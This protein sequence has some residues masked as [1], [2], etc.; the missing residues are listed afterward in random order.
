[1]D[2]SNDSAAILA[3]HLRANGVAVVWTDA[4][5]LSASHPLHSAACED[6]TAEADRYVTSYGYEVGQYG[7]EREAA[8]RISHLVEARSGHESLP[9]D[10]EAISATIRRALCLGSG[11]PEPDALTELEEELRGHI[12]LLLPEVRESA[13]RLWPN[14]VDAHRLKA[15]LDGIE[16]QTRQGLGQG[17]LSAHVQIHQLARDCQYLLTRHTAECR[18]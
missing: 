18:R 11:R 8:R 13:R 16:R 7:D 4:T 6:I 9:V 3:E 2:A 14:S 5:A 10:V 1:M 15:R 17:T 12:A